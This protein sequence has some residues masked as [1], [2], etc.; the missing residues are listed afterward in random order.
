MN[1]LLSYLKRFLLLLVV[2]L[3]VFVE[4]ALVSTIALIINVS[5]TQSR[6]YNEYMEYVDLIVARQDKNFLATVLEHAPMTSVPGY[7]HLSA[8]VSQGYS[9]GDGIVLTQTLPDTE[10]M[11]IHV[12]DTT[13]AKSYVATT[14]EDGII[15]L[16]M[17]SIDSGALDSIERGALLIWVSHPGRR[18]YIGY[19]DVWDPEFTL[20]VR[21]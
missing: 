16:T 1:R 2:I 19:F 7:V 18:P 4:L 12:K 5:V 8:K 10:I 17:D 3:L 11:L 20:T 6:Y 21:D 15:E 13:T 9:L 14:N